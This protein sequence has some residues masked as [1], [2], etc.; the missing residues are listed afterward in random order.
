M[1]FRKGQKD[2]R[3]RWCVYAEMLKQL[4]EVQLLFNFMY[5]RK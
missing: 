3:Y 4:E 2:G 5:D 1:R